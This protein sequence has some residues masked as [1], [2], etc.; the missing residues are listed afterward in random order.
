MPGIEIMGYGKT[1]EKHIIFLAN[2]NQSGT[3]RIAAYT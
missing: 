1:Q 2:T 3:S